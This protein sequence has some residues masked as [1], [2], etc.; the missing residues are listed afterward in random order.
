MAK[1]FISYNRRSEGVARDLSADVEALGHTVWLDQELSG[2]QVW[3]ERILATIRE[4]DVF[5]FVLDPQ[6]LNST[7][8]QRE[9]GYAGD[10]GKAVLPVLAADGIS[11]NLLPPVLSQVQFVDYRKKDRD[12]VLKLARAFTV[13]PASKPLP[14]PLP[15]PPEVPLSYLGSVAAR[16]DQAAMLTYEEQSA[17]I[18]DLR[19]ATRDQETRADALVLLRR[20]RKRRDLLAAVADEIDDV[21]RGLASPP[22]ARP[23]PGHAPP[24][25]A[26]PVAALHV[27]P[28]APVRPPD[29]MPERRKARVTP[30]ADG[31]HHPAAIALKTRLMS[32]MVF[33]LI[34]GSLVAIAIGA[35]GR[36]STQRNWLFISAFYGALPWA[37]AG[38]VVAGRAAILRTALVLAL[39][40][41]LVGW[42]LATGLGESEA[43]LVGTVLGGTPGLLAGTIAG[44][45]WNR[46]RKRVP[47]PAGT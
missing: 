18:V 41:L 22:D 31:G 45:L 16:V 7:A 38:A 19:G 37:V 28:P 40:G 47:V 23:I 9:Y 25:L 10:L 11:T 29:G 1:V 46:R 2:G 39:C 24:P 14:D 3:W 13:V 42:L 15:P 34:G 43:F 35:V 26:S 8:C 4:C 5:V 20:L 27:P 17:L 30:D 21:L 33:A 32:A 44:V 6:S 12:A 36:Y